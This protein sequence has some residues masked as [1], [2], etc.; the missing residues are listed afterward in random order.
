MVEFFLQ[1]FFDQ[2]F[3]LLKFDID[4]LYLSFV[5]DL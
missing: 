1:I 2:I 3:F 5:F 4:A